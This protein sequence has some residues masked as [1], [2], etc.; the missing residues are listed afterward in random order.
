MGT[1]GMDSG[2]RAERLL[3]A[4][5]ELAAVQ[6]E[7]DAVTAELAGDPEYSALFQEMD[8]VYA[9]AI[10]F[11]GWEPADDVEATLRSIIIEPDPNAD[12]DALAL[13]ARRRTSPGRCVDRRRHGS[14]RAQRTR[15][16][17]DRVVGRRSRRGRQQ[18]EQADQIAAMLERV[19]AD[20]E[21]ID[22]LAIE[23]GDELSTDTAALESRAE[24]LASEIARSG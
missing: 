1:V 6:A 24:E 19:E 5:D 11:I 17:G 20:E 2:D 16:T 13:P 23:L 14:H 8:Q 3:V 10:E 7:W 18:A 15:R 12:P 9:E 22:K 4:Q 21:S